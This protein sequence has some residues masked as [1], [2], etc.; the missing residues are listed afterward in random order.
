MAPNE[1]W[2][3]RQSLSFRFPHQNPVLQFSCTACALQSPPI[4]SNCCSAQQYWNLYLTVNVFNAHRYLTSNVKGKDCECSNDSILELAWRGWGR[5]QRSLFRTGRNL[6]YDA[7][8]PTYR[9]R[10]CR[11]QAT[12]VDKTATLLAFKK[13][14]GHYTDLRLRGEGRQTTGRG[15]SQLKLL[16][17]YYDNVVKQEMRLKSLAGKH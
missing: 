5:P 9:F 13:C 10:R 7:W 14:P 6:S 1:A 17:K 12:H 2:S 3:S 15:C 11:L 8:I 16:S 4:S